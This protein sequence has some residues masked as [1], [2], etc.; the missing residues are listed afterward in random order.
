MLR[1]VT[2]LCAFALLLVGTAAAQTVTTVAEINAIP[3]GQI[4]QLNTLGDAVTTGDLNSCGS[5]IYN[6][7]C[8]EAVKITVVVMSDPLNSGLASVNSEGRPGRVHIFVRDVATDTTGPEG[9]GIQVVDGGNL[10]IVGLVI[11]DVVEITGTVGPFN[12]TMQVSPTEAPVVIGSRDPATDPIFDPIMV[13]TSDLNADVGADGAIRVNWDNLGNLRGNYVRFEGASALTR[14]SGSR[15]DWNWTSDAGA[16]SVSMYDTSTRYRND[17]NDY[18]INFNTR[19]D[20]YVAPTPG[21][22]VNVQ[23][24]VTFNGGTSSDP[25]GLAVPNGVA[26]AVNPMEDAD[27]DIS[28]SP[29]AVNNVSLADGIPSSQAPVTITA[30]VV[31]D[32]A[33][34]LTGANLVFTTTSNATETT[35]AGAA[36]ADNVWSFEISSG[37]TDGDFADYRIEAT[38]DTGATTVSSG[39]SF[40]VLDG[41]IQRISHIQQTADGQPGDSPFVGQTIAMDITATVTLSAE[42]GNLAL[43]DGTEP[44]SGISLESVSG[45]SNEPA[46]L[47]DLRPGDVI[48]VTSARIEE[49]FGLTKFDEDNMSFTVVSTGGATL[50]P[51]VVPTDVL[52]DRAIAEAYEGMFLRIEDAVV[53]ATNADDPSGPFGEFELSSDGTSGNALRVDDASSLLSYTGNDPGTVFATGERLEFVQGI[54]WYSFSNFKLVPQSF[55]DIGAVTNTST[56][57]GEV[58]NAF[59]LHQNYPNPFNPSTSISFDMAQTADVTLAVYDVLGRNVATLVNGQMAS[60]RHTVT[61]DASSLTSGVYMYRIS[62]GSSTMTRTMLLMK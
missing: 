49:D 47:V 14:T 31:A 28:A 22:T 35:V 58:P 36:G 9:Q 5:L 39:F 15:V 46:G 32:P 13:T 34:S 1:Y 2:T 43:Q 18:P 25:F 3:Q 21:A 6:S 51:I 8:G 23:G 24:F 48:N 44:W 54:L 40:R 42:S 7:L 37:L 52:Q 55:D 33:R 16:S 19:T 11:G 29:P 41:G 17:R 12:T 27:V 50:D 30:E 4:D 20:D 61:F 10:G 59:T 62:N 26:L 45:G 57:D 38:D 53:T 56:E 60:G